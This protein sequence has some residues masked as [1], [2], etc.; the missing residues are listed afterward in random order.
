MW[1][2]GKGDKIQTGHSDP[3]CRYNIHGVVEKK[4][5]EVINEQLKH[6]S[7]IDQISVLFLNFWL[8]W[9]KYIERQVGLELY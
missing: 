2:E 4:A 3:F 5:K 7:I 9:L 8:L 6:F 1:G